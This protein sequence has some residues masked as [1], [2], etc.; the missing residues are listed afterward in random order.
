[1]ADDSLENKDL[2][3]AFAEI[4]NKTTRFGVWEGENHV[5]RFLKVVESPTEATQAS[6]LPWIPRSIEEYD[7]V[8]QDWTP[9][10]DLMHII[11][12]NKFEFFET[13]Q[14]CRNVMMEHA[15]NLRDSPDISQVTQEFD[16]V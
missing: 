5:K 8:E 15:T 10:E 7:F 16:G 12:S 9:K 13:P 11:N 2:S 14:D 4:P 1:M 6:T 3:K